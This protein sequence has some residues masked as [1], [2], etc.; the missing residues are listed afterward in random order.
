MS[1]DLSEFLGLSHPRRRECGVGLA[2]TQ[3]PEA[4]AKALQ[5]ALDTST[6][7]ITN[8]AVALWLER[9]GFAESYQRV[10]SHRRGS[11]TCND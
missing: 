11:C 3:L 7:I 6:G 8:Q 4:D 5:G 1:T 2:L 9:R 10:A